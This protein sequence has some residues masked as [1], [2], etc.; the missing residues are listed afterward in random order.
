M[1]LTV[2]RLTTPRYA[3]LTGEGARRA[4]GRWNPRGVAVV[5]TGDHPAL[6]VAEYLVHV[7]DPEDLPDALVFLRVVVP[8]DVAVGVVSRAALEARDPGWRRAGAPAC[9]AAGTAWL[10]AAAEPVLRVPSA[11]VPLAEN[12]LLNP[13]HPD[14]ARWAVAEVV[15][16]AF[17]PRLLD[18]GRR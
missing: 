3:D 13:A 10:A 6:A 4:G 1:P 15:P 18:P 2:W 7:R 11:V 17:E 14:A 12:V 8:D 9:L 5:Y 16:Y